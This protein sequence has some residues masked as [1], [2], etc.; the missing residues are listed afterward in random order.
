MK[1]G[2]RKNGKLNTP[3]YA[4]NGDYILEERLPDGRGIMYYKDLR[5]SYSGEFVRGVR[6]GYGTMTFPNG[7][8]FKGRWSNDE[9]IGI[10]TIVWNDGTKTK[11]P[12]PWP[13]DDNNSNASTQNPPD[14]DDADFHAWEPRI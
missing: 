10:G 11:G 1:G 8:T 12:Y 2:M 5:Y 13:D 14:D 6:Q 3:D 9:P 4:Y 7:T